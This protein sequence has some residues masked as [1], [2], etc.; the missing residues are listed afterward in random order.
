M[1]E[2]DLQEA[3]KSKAKFSELM[4]HIP[5]KIT[6]ELANYPTADGKTLVHIAE[7]TQNEDTFFNVLGDDTVANLP[8]PPFI[9]W[10]VTNEKEKIM[11][12]VN[13]INENT[14]SGFGI[15]VFKASLVDNKINIECLSKPKLKVK[16]SN[17][18]KA[19]KFQLEYWKKYSEV[20]DSLGEGD[21][22]IIP[23]PQHW[24][25]LP[26]GKTGVSIQLTLNTRDN[27]IGI[28][29]CITNNVQLFE[30]LNSHKTD[31]EQA[32]GTLEWVNKS[33]VK[34]ARIRKTIDVEF[35]QAD[36]DSVA[37]AHIETAKEFKKLISK[38]L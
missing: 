38:Y 8:Q 27:F 9:V 1:A 20:C 10:I 2:I 31:I 13:L 5:A 26:L 14:R 19:K 30:S 25:Y 24:Q 34:T 36:I 28:D 4:E 17:G 21:Y 22:Q 16:N 29:L 37:K 33:N 12:I 6:Q 7:L 3:F 15:F 11:R 35:P 23:K 32:L 18:G